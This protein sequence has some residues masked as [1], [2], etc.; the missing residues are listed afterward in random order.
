VKVAAA[1]GAATLGALAAQRVQTRH[2]GA[3]LRVHGVKGHRQQHDR[4]P[5]QKKHFLT[6]WKSDLG[7][8]ASRWKH[9]HVL[10]AIDRWCWHSHSHSGKKRIVQEISQKKKKKKFPFFK[11]GKEKKKEWFF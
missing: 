11:D 2:G 1:V 9:N 4:D 7:G 10:S 3:R 5:E 6:W 8:K